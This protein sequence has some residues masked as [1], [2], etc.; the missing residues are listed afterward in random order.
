[1]IWLK[2]LKKWFKIVSLSL[3]TMISYIALLRIKTRRGKDQRALVFPVGLDWEWL[4]VKNVFK[5]LF[6]SLLYF[7]QVF[8]NTQ[9]YHCPW[10]GCFF[11]FFKAIWLSANK[12]LY[13]TKFINNRD[14]LC[15]RHQCVCH[16]DFTESSSQ[17]IK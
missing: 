12:P 4:L 15:C 17:G 14:S 10:K 1:M 6:I 8:R 7:N 13:S 16:A 9:K 5:Q 11:F 3:A 2:R